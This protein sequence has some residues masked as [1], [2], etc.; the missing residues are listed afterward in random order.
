MSILIKERTPEDK[1][2]LF[3]KIAFFLGI[4]S[5]WDYHWDNGDADSFINEKI[6]NNNQ[7]MRCWY[8]KNT[9]ILSTLSLTCL[10][11]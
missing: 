10:L 3:K 4:E 7:K 11:I 8:C 1:F 2:Y 9:L 6:T 5:I